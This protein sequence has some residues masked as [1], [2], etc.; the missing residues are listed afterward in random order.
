MAQLPQIRNLATLV[1]S[2]DKLPLTYK[3]ETFRLFDSF[4]YHYTPFLT[5]IRQLVLHKIYLPISPEIFG[6]FPNLDTLALVGVAMDKTTPPV[7]REGHSSRSFERPT[8]QDL[9]VN[10]FDDSMAFFLKWAG[11]TECQVDFAK[12]QRCRVSMSTHK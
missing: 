11:E 3:E 8:V 4:K 5:S 6:T 9:T 1:I 12:M 7:I 10:L 2:A